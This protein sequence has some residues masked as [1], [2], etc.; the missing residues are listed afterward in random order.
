MRFATRRALLCL[1]LPVGLLAPTSAEPPGP[2]PQIVNG[3]PSTNWPSVAAL[4]AGGSF[5]SATFIGCR[6]V[7]TA[8]HCVCDPGGTGPA[9]PD[10][11]FLPDPA[12]VLW[13]FLQHESDDFI[14]ES[15]RVAPGYQFGVSSDVAVLK[16]SD[17]MRSI[18]PAPINTSSAPDFGTAGTIV[19]WGR[20]T[21]GGYDDAGVKRVGAVNTGGCAGSGVPDATHVCWSLQPPVGPPGTDS[22]ICFGDSGGPLFVDLEAGSA[23]AG[24]HSGGVGLC[25]VND[26]SFAADVYVDHSWIQ[27]QDFADQANA[28]CGDG[29]QVGDPEVTTQ[30]F[31]GTA[32]S[33]VSHS[34]SVPPGTKELRVSLNA[35]FGFDNDFDLYIRFGSP[36]TV[37]IF[38]C[39]SAYLGST[40]ECRIVD[41]SP[42]TWHILVNVTSGG[43]GDYQVV[44]TMLP[45]NP[46]PPVLALGDV[47]VA[48]FV[49]RGELFQLDR[50]SGDRAITSASLRGSGPELIFP[51]DVMSD[52]DGSILVTNVAARSLVRADPATGD[53]SVVS[54][55][56]D[57]ACTSQVGSGPEFLNPRLITRDDDDGSFLVTDRSENT[58]CAVVRVDPT[59]GDRIV[60]SGCTDAACSSQVGSGPSMERVFG[61]EVEQSGDILV[62]DTLALL[63]ID[64]VNGNRSVLS[65][66][67]DPSCTVEVGTGPSFGEPIGV[68]IE[69]SG[70][71]LLTDSSENSTFSALFR[72][73]PSTGA[74]TIV[75]GCANPE[76]S[77]VIG[78]GPNFIKAW[79]IAFEAD[80][81]PLITDRGLDAVL[82]VD[83]TTGDRTVVS[84]CLDASCAAAAG[85]GTLL[86]EPLGIAVVPEPSGWLSLGA[87]LSF[88]AFLSRRRPFPSDPNRNGTGLGSR[89]R[90]LSRPH[91]QD[92]P[93]GSS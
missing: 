82:H 52:L 42:G 56:V 9:C 60:V 90:Y 10:G 29:P 28:A 12:E 22:T 26:V 68:G 5:C 53:R 45:E 49:F 6:T 18:R 13:V 55:C 78:A 64:A 77:S 48:D 34:L 93:A 70:D 89:G 17:S 20:T 79:G 21:S 39:A 63:R 40:E 1:L 4:N 73:D 65:G 86:S 72:V 2:E 31:D 3:L 66:C 19:G 37:S 84:G 67:A 25:Q 83:P 76:C 35:E 69:A 59:S 7:L 23:V 88:L 47:V 75:S 80:G 36:P 38:D 87:G 81:D 54:G 43:P 24:V 74:R 16:L 44:G 71:V 58:V 46:A 15:V 32:I 51:E 91:F 14:V 92:K 41:P 8:A 50:A 57:A 61:I 85:S 11:T 27:S 30:G 62:A 33:Q